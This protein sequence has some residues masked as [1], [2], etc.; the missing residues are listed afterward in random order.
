MDKEI[1][2]T[3][4]NQDFQISLKLFSDEDHPR[5]MAWGEMLVSLNNE[6]VWCS[7][8]ENAE[9]LPVVWAWIELLEFLGDKWPWLIMEERYPV[10]INP[11]HPGTMRYEAEK[12]WEGMGEESYLEEDERLFRFESRHDL[13]MGMKGIFLPSLF[14]LRQGKRVWICS[15]KVRIL[16]GF[17]ETVDVLT[18]L[19][20]CLA[21][22]IEDTQSPR[23]ERAVQ[24]WRTREQR[25]GDH[26]WEL[27]TSMSR[28]LRSSL[29]QGQSPQ[30]FWEA[31]PESLTFD[32]ELLAAARLSAGVVSLEQQ[33]LILEHIREVPFQKVQQ[34]DQVA[35]MVATELHAGMR[36]YE[37]GY[38]A[39]RAL[40][41]IM[42]LDPEKPADPEQILSRWGVAVRDISLDHCPLDAV[43]AWGLGH[44]PVVILNTGE[45]SRPAHEHGRRSTLAHEICHLLVDRTGA[46]PFAEALGGHTAL[47]VEQRARAF[48][49]EFLLPEETGVQYVRRYA[50]LQEALE[51]MNKDFAV[52]IE[53][54]AL[55][56]K[57]SRLF[58][59]LSEEEQL[60]LSRSTENHTASN[61]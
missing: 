17:Q 8:S 41:R 54:A 10:P 46:L 56:I 40:R 31:D 25:A 44:G 34:L 52:S 38:T 57:N 42:K 33:K 1:R 29:E 32:N 37:Q 47:Y 49:A 21:G 11:F 12:R 4:G 5:S 7:E 60:I 53:L 20:E 6:P 23:S 35:D 59:Q 50:G 58:S 14:V 39:A 48:A 2:Q 45:G 30:E 27:R 26:F 22:F 43:A 3:I 55:Q 15:D 18:N 61:L 24:R 51:K 16:T 13:A 28:D 36:P 19:G 9:E